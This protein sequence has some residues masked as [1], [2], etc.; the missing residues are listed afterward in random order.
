MS[1]TVATSR[2][3]SLGFSTTNVCSCW[4]NSSTF[5]SERGPLGGAAGV[6]GVGRVSPLKLTMTSLRRASWKQAQSWFR[7][8]E[9]VIN[10]GYENDRFN[11]PCDIIIMSRMVIG[12]DQVVIKMTTNDGKIPFLT[13][14]VILTTANG[15]MTQNVSKRH[16]PKNVTFL[17]RAGFEPP[18][19]DDTSYKPDA[20][21]TKPPSVIRSYM[22]NICY[23]TRLL[24]PKKKQCS[25]TRWWGEL[26]VLPNLYNWKLN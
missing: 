24:L 26:W 12:H 3:F 25:P 20:L 6:V 7:P 21:P 10:V 17:A 23:W 11:D 14:I 19:A 5:S 22:Y 16:F 2:S 1:L 4:T 9:G 13:Q 18:L 8:R 15:L